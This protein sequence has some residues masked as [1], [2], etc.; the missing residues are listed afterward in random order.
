[1]S[2]KRKTRPSSPAQIA[3]RR[4]AR[5]AVREEAE[6]L[7]AQGAEVSTDPQSGRIKGAYKPD[8]VVM[9]RRSEEI[10]P[11]DEAAVRKLEALI[12]KAAAAPA[13]SLSALDR[14]IGGEV[15]DH[16]I[17]SRIEAAQTLMQWSERMDAV[18]WAMARE[19]CD[20]N[21]LGSRWRG[22]ILR[23]TGERNPKAQAGIARQV[24]RVL[25]A[26]SEEVARARPP[27][28]DDLAPD[29]VR[30]LAG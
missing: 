12:A 15:G 18:T 7:R 24:F 14:V 28:N 3:A 11:S 4:A 22:V 10:T 30:A 27:A 25:A 26:V 2:R 1:M 8:V 17:G 19:L 20:G 6:R 16:G 5:Q 21:L 29:V 9:M 13:C 23:R